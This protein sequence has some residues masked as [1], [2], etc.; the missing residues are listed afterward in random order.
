MSVESRNSL[1]HSSRITALTENKTQ[2]LSVWPLNCSRLSLIVPCGRREAMN[3]YNICRNCQEILNWHWPIDRRE[4]LIVNVN[5]GQSKFHLLRSLSNTQT[6]T[7][8][9]NFHKHTKIET[10][11]EE[12][13]SWAQYFMV[14]FLQHFSL[15][16]SYVIQLFLM[17]LGRCACFTCNCLS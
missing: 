5:T 15:L 10:Q 3:K 9:K 12:Q 4:L 1:E 11:E 16:L 2:F 7:A 17:A 6:H 8:L 14:V 13:S